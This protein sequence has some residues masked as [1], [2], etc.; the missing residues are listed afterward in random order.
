MGSFRIAL[1]QINPT[2]GDLDGNVAR[3]AATIDAARDAGADLV[4]FPEL[5]VC[6]YPPEDLLL[7]PR[8]LADSRA[9]LDAVVPHTHGIAALV[10]FPNTKGAKA[11]NAAALIHDTTLVGIYHKIELPNYRVFDE[12]RYFEPG[13]G[14]LVFELNALR[15]SVTICEDV[16]VEG[17]QPEHYAVRNGA[18]VILNLSASPYHTGKLE[19][20][21]HVLARFARRTG[22]YLCYCNLVGGQDE[23][24]FDGGS[25]ILSPNGEPLAAAH[26]FEDDLLLADLS[27]DQLA[28]KP[29]PRQANGRWEKRIAI[30][31]ANAEG[32]PP[33]RGTV[34][35]RL[36]R[37]REIHKALVLGTRDYVH[38]NGFT[39]AVI[40]LSGGID[41]SLTAVLAVEALGADN[42]VGVTMPS[43]YTSPETRSDAERLAANLGIPLLTIPIKPIF[44]AYLAALEKDS[45]CLFPAFFLPRARKGPH[46]PHRP[47]PADPAE[48]RL[49]VS[50]WGSLPRTSR[51]GSAATC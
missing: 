32:R 41:S 2:V 28:T 18:G 8:F 51:R 33:I 31:S 4:A 39:K 38:K 14:C 7:K 3:I 20:R 37:V 19:E 46:S 42:V 25:L 17:G 27:V 12:K 43:Q 26:R 45:R 40:G 34:A 16:W 47:L 48:K 6:G 5:A 49:Q 36:D 11:C 1:A 23:L 30:R 50:F 9:A 35:Q 29:A 13:A 22:A 21:R 44:D 15:V 10:G 24:V